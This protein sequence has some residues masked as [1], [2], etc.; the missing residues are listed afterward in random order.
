MN[1]APQQRASLL[2]RLDITEQGQRD[3]FIHYLSSGGHAVGELDYFAKIF[4]NR[5]YL[6]GHRLVTADDATL[7]IPEV[8]TA[9]GSALAELERLGARVSGE[10]SAAI[11]KIQIRLKNHSSSKASSD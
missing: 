8:S 6:Y 1:F 5:N 10:A 3:L 11:G 4:P 7:T 9:D 2:S